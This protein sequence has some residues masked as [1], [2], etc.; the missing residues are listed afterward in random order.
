MNLINSFPSEVKTILDVGCGTGDFLQVAKEDNWT[1]SGIEP[2]E[3][4][5][6]VANEK[7][8]NWND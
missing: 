7:T 1:I 5:R 8:N 3:K 2:N 6:I 4:A